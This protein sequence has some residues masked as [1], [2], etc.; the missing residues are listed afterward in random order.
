MDHEYPSVL[1]NTIPY[2]QCSCEYGSLHAC[3]L[4]MILNTSTI[5]PTL[6]TVMV[7]AA[8]ETSLLRPVPLVRGRGWGEGEGMLIG[9]HLGA[10]GQ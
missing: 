1:V 7:R 5:I 6:I 10:A 3:G 8:M 4:F 2:T 9:T